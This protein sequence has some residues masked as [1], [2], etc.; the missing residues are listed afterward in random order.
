MIKISTILSICFLLITNALLAQITVTG[1]VESGDDETTLPGVSVVI[2]GTTT[3]TVT[4]I[5]GNYQLANVPED[6]TLVFSFVG[7]ETTEVPVNNQTVIDV[8]LQS[9]AIGIDEVVVIGYGTARSSD[10]TAP[11]PVISG[12]D[13]VRNVATNAVSALQGSSPGVQIVNRGEP[14]STPQIIVRGIGSMQGAQPLYVVDG[15]FY[16]DI[17]WVSPNDIESIALLKDASAA[18]IYGVRAAGGVIMVTTKQGRKGE[19]LL[20]EYDGY[21]G[22]N[23]SSNLME[24][25]NTEQYSAILIEQDAYPR[26]E[27]SI[28]L[29]GGRPFTHNGTEYTIPSTNTDWYDELLSTGMVMNHSLSL[30]GGNENTSYHIGG[31]YLSEEGL[32]ESDNQFERVNLKATVNFN[33]Y[34]F[35]DIGTNIVVSHNMSRDQGSVWGGMYSAVPII[36][37]REDNGDFAGVIQA[38]YQVGPVNNPAAQLHFNTGNHNFTRGTNLMYNAHTNIRLLGDDRL[39]FR[40]QFSHELRN[41]NSRVYNP[42][43][44]VDEKL[45]NENSSLTKRYNQY[46]SIHLDH[47][48]TFKENLADHNFTLMGGF[49]TRRV[50]AQNAGGSAQNVPNGPPEY[51]YFSNAI[52]PD[53]VN[54]DVF[55]GGY[56]ERGVS[57][58]GRLMYNYNYKYL[59]NATF[60]GDGTDKY[61]QTWGYFPSVGFGWVISEEP[62]MED[63]NLFQFMKV[64]AS[65]GQLGNNNVPRESGTREIFT[66]FN[67]SYVFGNDMIVPGYVSSVF[68]NE[69]EWELTEETNAGIELGLL[70]ER[71]YTEIDYF[72]R[73]TRNAAIFT[74]NLMGAGGMIRNAGEFVNRGIELSMTWEDQIGD[75]GYSVKGNMGTLHNEVLDLAGEPYI[76]AGSAEFRL[77]SEVGHPLY[78]YYGY[79]VIGVYQTA[80]E[81]EDHIDTEIHGQVEPGFLKYEDIDGN[82]IINEEDRQYLGANIPD[83]TYGGQ[84]SLDYR[85]FDLFVSVYGVSGNELIN[86][87][88]GNRAWHA[89]FNFDTDLYENRWVGQGSSNTYPSSRGLVNS[90]NLSPLNSFLVE[91]GSFFR[92]QN[93]TLGYTFNDPLPGSQ[94]G[95]K[96]RIRLAAQNPFT[97]FKFNGFT[98]EVTGQGLAGGVYPIPTSYIVGLNIT[99]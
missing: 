22:Y 39:V 64:R 87:L 69:L 44:F 3:G 46:S 12:T 55:D 6:G 70:D 67:N 76:D 97:F 27:P 93:I 28:N 72:N 48:L 90:W 96:I 25:S 60:R 66:G 11:I 36:P 77:R 61:S 42:V 2:K 68:F 7:M 63:Q 80:Q 58:F 9:D 79:K 98:P 51:F 10:L 81:V 56:A 13:I 84:I 86:T 88:R 35:L 32:L 62:F 45:R 50:D 73:V 59:I 26:L 92:I 74:R 41:G 14:G 21:T 54:F 71:L 5:D 31:S 99:Y 20:I 47:T 95:S 37:V 94:R 75:F 4:D 24:M 33:P 83:F 65:W 18:S 49:S 78:S 23:S 34:K 43:Y 19:G 40:T 8:T 1:T 91:D 89:D 16:D 38:G 52:D 82:G 15:M 53:P 57:F 30:R 29:W 17:N 85:N